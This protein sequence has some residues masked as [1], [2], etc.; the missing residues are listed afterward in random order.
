MSNAFGS[1][2]LWEQRSN[3]APLWG[4]PLRQIGQINAP[5]ADV[6]ADLRSSQPL[7]LDLRG[8]RAT[9]TMR[10]PPTFDLEARTRIARCP[11]PDN[12][13]PRRPRPAPREGCLRRC[14]WSRP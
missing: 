4:L 1:N 12:A 3:E 2:V 8:E 10:L 7:D 6:R 13:V 11:S 5:Y 14:S 9:A